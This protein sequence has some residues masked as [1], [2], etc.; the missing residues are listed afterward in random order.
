MIYHIKAIPKDELIKILE[1]CD[2]PNFTTQYIAAL[3]DMYGDEYC[4]D[5]FYS[6]YELMEENKKRKAVLNGEI[7]LPFE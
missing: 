6:D 5:G 1:K 2:A 4:K 3:F 7:K